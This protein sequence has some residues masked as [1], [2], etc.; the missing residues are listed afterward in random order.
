[1]AEPKNPRNTASVF[2]TDEPCR[3][4][5]AFQIHEEIAGAIAHEI[6][7][8][9]PGNI[10]LI[11]N[12]GSG[13]ST[14]VDKVEELLTSAT[15]QSEY[16]DASNGTGGN[17]CVQP[18]I[19]FK[20][21]A[22]THS[23]DSLRR[24]F[25]TKLSS[26]LFEE[27]EVSD[28]E[29]GRVEDSIYGRL[30]TSTIKEDAT[31]APLVAA[32][33]VSAALFALT[34][35]ILD[36]VRPAARALLVS[37]G[38]LS[39]GTH[40]GL[41]TWIDF[42]SLC[43]G[44]F[45]FILIT[46]ALRLDRANNSDNPMPTS[47][48]R[49]L[50]P[51]ER[52]LSRFKNWANRTAQ[53]ITN[54]FSKS[55]DS[56]TVTK[57]DNSPILD[58][59]IFE[60]QF[61]KLV[62]L[63]KKT[64]VIV[65]DNLDRLDHE[66]L[67]NT[68]STLQIFA[69]CFNLSDSEVPRKENPPAKARRPWILLPIS[70]GAFQLMDEQGLDSGGIS[71]SKLF[72]RVFEIP[73]PITSDWRGYFLSQARIAFP[74]SSEEVLASVYAAASHAL[75]RTESRTPRNAKR[76]INSMVA[77]A[78]VY[79]S[80]H[81]TS[82]AV[83]CFIKD[84]YILLCAH[85]GEGEGDN[86]SSKPTFAEYMTDIIAGKSSA[87]HHIDPFEGYAENLRGDLAM[88]AYGLFSHE[89][90]SE[91]FVGLQMRTFFSGKSS[92]DIYDLVSGNQGSWSL[93]TRETESE[94]AASDSTTTPP[95]VFKM[96]QSLYAAGSD[97][98]ERDNVERDHLAS[99]LIG[100]ISS[101]STR[102][103]SYGIAIASFIPKCQKTAIN[104]LV[105]ILRPDLSEHM[106]TIRRYSE[107]GDNA[108]LSKALTAFDQLLIELVPILESL[109]RHG[110]KSTKELVESNLSSIDFGSYYG[111]FFSVCCTESENTNWLYCRPPKNHGEMSA[112][113]MLATEKVLE[114]AFDDPAIQTIRDA[115][116]LDSISLT[117]EDIESFVANQ[118]S[119]SDLSFTAGELQ[120]ACW[121]L[122]NVCD[123]D[124]S[125]FVQILNYLQPE[126]T[127]YHSFGD[128]E[129][130]H[131]SAAVLALAVTSAIDDE[132]LGDLG[133]DFFDNLVNPGTVGFI[134]ENEIELLPHAIP[135]ANDGKS[136]L[137]A[138]CKKLAEAL[139][140][141]EDYARQD[142][143][144]CLDFI[145]LDTTRSS[146]IAGGKLLGQ[147]NRAIDFIVSDFSHTWATVYRWVLETTPEELREAYVNW[148]ADQI[149][150]MTTRDWQDA[151]SLP[152]ADD[153]AHIMEETTSDKKLPNLDKAIEETICIK[154]PADNVLTAI[155][156]FIG[157][158]SANTVALGKALAANNSLV[159][160]HLPAYAP[161]LKRCQWFNALSSQQRFETIKNL[162]ETHRAY[163]CSALAEIISTINNPKHLLSGH[164]KK[165]KEILRH[166]A[167]LQHM[168]KAG[169]RACA[170]ILDLLK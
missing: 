139:W 100:R 25:L 131:A 164:L 15:A 105:G 67:R 18:V 73:T 99:L 161:V 41:T 116:I 81:L 19:Y 135:I 153:L 95:W 70:G 120:V 86:A 108:A 118:A 101:L 117:G 132:N 75:L 154:A 11:G 13:K 125:A 94:L 52:G 165:T 72:I 152:Q 111:Y 50:K 149:Q 68:W 20:F 36:A 147:N 151:I 97:C 46:I 83:F 106:E 45:T 61:R 130:P 141:D 107:D 26:K 133:E 8:G 43:V 150:L 115:G 112:L 145:S 76:F 156:E 80:I 160:N 169:K 77:Q 103:Q 87:S 122:C 5:S 14:I 66:E 155:A 58:S 69:S 35:L 44:A 91:V 63:G 98:F 143:R 23:G 84:D 79:P 57:R 59:L 27:G 4:Q 96:L 166:Q 31:F 144:C 127:D 146:H 3:N 119:D 126:S 162:V 88:M 56:T 159:V 140:R 53:Y 2:L 34:N 124:A 12:W 38:I 60:E 110:G 90:A 102:A 109:C 71:I 37:I 64:I 24:S 163:N 29:R 49:T 92:L 136:N 17:E 39:P 148:L 89:A 85:D 158:Y 65:F 7:T 48:S 168:P 33:I 6:K 157:A 129:S 21:D 62:N 55:S 47:A 113:L 10:A 51:K 78:R 9:E 121:L 104:H 28:S 137:A 1:M 32:A 134:L 16:K 142:L 114:G 22:W 170:E 128:G 40:T 167:K 82:I 93:I 30:S 74:E 138:V 123:T 54:I 42:A